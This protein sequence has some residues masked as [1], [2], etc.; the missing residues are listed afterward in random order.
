[1][2]MSDAIAV[3][4]STARPPPPYTP[5]VEKDSITRLKEHFAS[6][7]NDHAEVQRLFNSVAN[8]L[9]SLDQ[10]GQHHPLYEEWSTL[11]QQHRRLHRSSVQN[12]GR[13]A[14]FLTNFDEVIRPLSQ[15]DGMSVQGKIFMIGKFR[16]AVQI[17]KA[18][19]RSTANEFI[20]VGET[21]EAFKLKIAGALRQHAE[22]SN[23]WA[24][25]WTGLEHLLMNVWQ[26]LQKLLNEMINVI[27]STA[28]RI[29]RIRVSCIVQIVIEMDELPNSRMTDAQAKARVTTTS[30]IRDNIDDLTSR[31]SVFHD[32]WNVV[33]AACEDLT[34]D[35]ELAR[36]TIRQS[37]PRDANLQSARSVYIVLRECMRA[38]SQNRPP[39]F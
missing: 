3:T 1:M 38:Y 23:I 4:P 22:P 12:A 39:R 7:A 15:S 13:C 18:A 20:Q 29:K 36:A 5:T 16:D 32:V 11:S 34:V 27:R 26:A 2:S 17:H 14:S 10:I 33:D 30:D 35:L 28:M 21:I 9:E 19:A 37:G 25:I 31:L 6:L 24:H 8:Q